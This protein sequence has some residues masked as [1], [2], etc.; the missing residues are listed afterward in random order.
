MWH[1]RFFGTILAV[2]AF[3]GFMGSQT[4]LA[5]YPDSPEFSMSQPQG[6]RGLE[7]SFQLAVMGSST[8]PLDMPPEKSP[9][10]VQPEKPAV[11]KPIAVM[12]DSTVP[13][14]KSAARVQP[15]KP[16]VEQPVA[17]Q[18]EKPKKVSKPKKKKV[19]KANVKKAPAKKPV[20]EEGFLTKTFKQLL[21]GGDDKKKAAAKPQ[22]QKTAGK[23]PEKE[24]EEEGFLTKTLKTLMG[25]EKKEKTAKKNPLNPINMAPTGSAT[26]KQGEE[27]SKTA[28]SE[29]KKTLKDSFE[30]LIGVGAVKDKGDTKSA[31]TDKPAEAT[32]SAKKKESGGLLDSILGGSGKKKDSSTTKQA[33]VKDTVKKSTPAKPKRITAKKYIEEEE[34][35]EEGQMNKNYAGAKKGKN[36]LKESFKTLIADDKKKTDEE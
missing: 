25:G 4:V 27:Q 9:A 15:E 24:K 28:K 32:K 35:Q 29:T 31:K 23:V 13:P 22:M 36:V 7:G 17:I 1:S 14:E 11:K 21:G 34:G 18:K 16:A 5:A 2:L 8:A 19:K 3:P 6:T 10:K 26:K 33:K 12:R 20:E 30:K